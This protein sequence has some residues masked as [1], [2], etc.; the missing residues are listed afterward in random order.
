MDFFGFLPQMTIDLAPRG[1]GLG[2]AQAVHQTQVMSHV[3]IAVDVKRNAGQPRAQRQCRQRCHRCHPE[4]HEQKDLLVEEVDRKDALDGVALDV[5]QP[6]DAEVAQ[7]HTREARRRRPVVSGDHRPQDVD[8]EQV[9]VLAEEQ[10]ESE[11]LADDVGEK[12]QLDGD[13]DGNQVVAMTTTA[14]AETGA[15]ETVLEANVA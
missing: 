4:P 11:Q 8:A 13:V 1:F 15:R 10:V 12:Q 6:P 5:G 9:E 7:R 14:A 3:A 2:V